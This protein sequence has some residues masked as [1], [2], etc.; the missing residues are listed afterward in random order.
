LDTASVKELKENLLVQFPWTVLIGIGQGGMARSSDTQMFQLTLT[1]SKTSGNLTEGMGATQLAKQHGYKLTPTSKS[2]GMTFCPG[3]HDPM[4]KVH[5]RKKLQQL[6]KYATK[7]IHKW[8]S[9]KCEIGFADS[10]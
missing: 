2:F 1:A 7:S 9:F 4:L 10:I 6:A 8:P 3:D 5:T